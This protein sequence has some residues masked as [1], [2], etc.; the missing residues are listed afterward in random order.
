[1]LSITV[2]TQLLYVG[3]GEATSQGLG[4]VIWR[5]ETVAY[6]V[7][8]LYALRLARQHPIVAAGLLLAGLFNVVQLGIGLRMFGPVRAEGVPEPVGA[9][10]VGMAFFLFFAGK[11]ALGFSAT[12]LGSVL[13]RGG[14]GGGVRWA[15]LAAMIAGVA[16]IALCMMAMLMGEPRY[17]FPAGAAG[18]AAALLTA[19]AL[20]LVYR[21]GAQ[22]GTN[23]DS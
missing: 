2:L 19:I 22:A 20:P 10:V 1:M 6:L 13:Y 21:S 18:A 8:A 7:V 23:A 17:T 4:R 11:F 12:G 14:G 5:V 9:A 16:A 15:G 3:A